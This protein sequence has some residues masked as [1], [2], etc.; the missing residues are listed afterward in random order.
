MV[1]VDGVTQ[2]SNA[3]SVSGTTL[4][5]TSAPSAGTGNIFVNTISPVGSTI[6]HPASDP[7]SAST[8]TFSGKITADAGIDIDNFNIDGTTIALSSGD[9][10]LD[11]AGDIILDADGADVILKDGGTTFLEIDKDGNNARIKNPIADGDIKF[12]GIDSSSVVTALT[13]DMSAAGEATFNAGVNATG[14][15]R[16]DLFKC[17]KYF[18][19]SIRFVQLSFGYKL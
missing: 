3:Y 16:C 19:N 14:I 7:L 17:I 10:T 1:S 11:A 13:L 5:F 6:T 9:M 4:T 2:D 12:Q 8:G 15:R 18:S